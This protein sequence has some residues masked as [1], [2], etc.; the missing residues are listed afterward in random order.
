MMI[1]MMVRKDVDGEKTATMISTIIDGKIREGRNGS[2]KKS[3]R[4][5]GLLI[6]IPT[7]PE[8]D[9][10]TNIPPII[11]KKKKKKAEAKPTLHPLLKRETDSEMSLGFDKKSQHRPHRLT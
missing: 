4:L 11:R 9:V 1:M 3:G 5:F 10:D 7:T 8:R 6:S 2:C